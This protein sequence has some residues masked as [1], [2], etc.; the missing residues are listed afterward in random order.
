MYDNAVSQRPN[1]LHTICLSVLCHF[2]MSQSLRSE[3]LAL[4]M[5]LRF[6]I[7]SLEHL[8]YYL[9]HICNLFEYEDGDT[10]ST[11]YYNLIE[12]GH[13]A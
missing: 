4:I 6:L 9:V 1:I 2:D 13:L 7:S 5:T 8:I 12:P 3:R 11:Y 10:D